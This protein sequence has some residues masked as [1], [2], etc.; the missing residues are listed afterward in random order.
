[1]RD[2]DQQ[3]KHSPQEGVSAYRRPFIVVMLWIV[4]MLIGFVSI[5]WFHEV[6]L[7]DPEEFFPADSRHRISGARIEKEFPGAS[8]IS[9]VALIIEAPG[10]VANESARI[11]ALADRLRARLPKSDVT[12]VLAPTDNAALQKRL[13]APDGCAALIVVQLTAGFGSESGAR[14]VS[15][16]EREVD[17]SR[18][19]GFAVSI[20]GDATLGRDYDRAI[21][22]GGKRSAVATIILVV[23]ILLLVYRSPVAA[24]VS[25]FSLAAAL[26]VTFGLVTLSAACGVRVAYH[27]RSFIVAI[28]YG[29]GT[30]YCLLLFSRVREEYAA[31]TA[32]PVGTARRASLSVIVGS[33][34]AVALACGLMTFADFGL[35]RYSGFALA[36]G[37]IAAMSATLTLVPALMRILGPHLFWPSKSPAVSVPSRIWPAVSRLIL[38]RPFGTLLVV[39]V[40]LAPVVVSG[41]RAQPIF[42]DVVDIPAGSPSEAG[43]AALG[44]HFSLAAIAPISC[45]IHI[46]S[47][48]PEGL[49]GAA[50]LAVIHNFTSHLRRVPGVAAVYSASQPTGEPGLLDSGTIRGQMM[51]IE[52]GLLAGRRGSIAIADGL[53]NAIDGIGRLSDQGAELEGGLERACMGASEISRGLRGAV[54]QITLGIDGIRHQ[55]AALEQDRRSSL[56]G[57]F[58][59]RRLD[60]AIEDLGRFQADME[61]LQSGLGR[62]ITGADA[63]ESGLR[64]G[65]ERMRVPGKETGAVNHLRRLEEGLA[66]AARGS[67]ELSDGLERGAQRLQMIR[68]SPDVA[69]ALDRLVLSPGDI[70]RAPELGA[71]LDHYV[72]ASGRAA[73]FEIEG[74]Y[75]PHSPDAVGVLRMLEMRLPVWFEAMGYSGAVAYFGG[76]TP[77]TADLEA[78]TRSDLTRIGAC[79]VAGVFVLLVF[80]LSDIVLAS[81]VTV[82]LLASYFAALGV[83]TLGVHAGYWPGI[84]WKAPFFLFVLLVAIGA[85]YGIFLLGRAREEAART[86]FREGLA[87]ALEATGPVVSSCGLVLAGTFAALALAPISFLQQVGLGVT[88]G[89]LIDTLLVRPFMLPATALLLRRFSG[90]NAS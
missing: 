30:D 19:A 9:Q 87:R 20:S 28:V 7:K 61:R 15:E 78:I 4:S 84:D 89:V 63:I 57:I 79:V 51:A 47:E 71:V 39:A 6:S 83:L 38:S 16:V 25:V 56:T 62:A 49:H 3:I 54:D 66:R 67:R 24:G 2:E 59:R 86:S 68:S 44:R 34:L 50:G 80:L 45:V 43:Y 22:A 75:S 26:G 73:L 65:I 64:H 29:V 1:M 90:G 12:A 46:D 42:D 8:P 74:K 33:A 52:S 14:V 35:F 70:D 31:G 32:D 41:L 88:A 82:Y 40:L 13:I 23:L 17:S 69:G 81:A 18:A 60:R 77:I 21:D 72:S 58:A 36:V 27:A 11:T 55:Q 5:P 76:A 85:D 48:W 10:G 53:Q 37:V